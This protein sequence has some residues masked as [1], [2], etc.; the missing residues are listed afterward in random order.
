MERRREGTMPWKTATKIA[1]RNCKKIS[2]NN[3]ENMVYYL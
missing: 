2:W 1:L 3:I